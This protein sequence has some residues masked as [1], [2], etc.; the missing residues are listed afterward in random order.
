METSALQGIINKGCFF[1][2][3]IHKKQEPKNHKVKTGLTYRLMLEEKEDNGCPL[4]FK[5][6]EEKSQTK[7]KKTDQDLLHNPPL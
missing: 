3:I 6:V 2:N 4:N 7:K 1:T 5:F